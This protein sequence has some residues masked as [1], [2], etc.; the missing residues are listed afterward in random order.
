MT[1][2][3]KLSRSLFRS[4]ASAHLTL[5]ISFLGDS[6]SIFPS[7][8]GTPGAMN[9]ICYYVS[10]RSGDDSSQ[11]T[12][13]WPTSSPGPK[14]TDRRVRRRREAIRYS[15]QSTPPVPAK[16]TREAEPNLSSLASELTAR[17]QGSKCAGRPS[18]LPA[19]EGKYLM[20]QDPFLSPLTLTERN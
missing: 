5:Q 9:S 3:I 13:E 10:N 7:P 11:P 16:L 20:T 19:V 4:E 17:C 14:G 18:P 15:I 12:I 2:T 6:A 8:V 1:E